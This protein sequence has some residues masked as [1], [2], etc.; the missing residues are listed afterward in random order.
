[1]FESLDL[2]PSFKNSIMANINNNSLSHA[3][4]LEGGD[5]ATRLAV[6]K[7]IA[8]AVMCK[9]ENKPCGKCDKCRKVQSDNHPDIYFLR[10]DKKSLVI[11][12]DPVRDLKR[13]ALVLPN[14]GDKSIFII[15]DAQ[16]MNHLAQ[17]AFLKIFEEPSPHVLFIL[18]CDTKAS[19]LE[20]VISR[21]TCYNLGA[22]K[23]SASASSPKKEKATT[24][25]NELLLCLVEENEVSFLKRIAVLQKDKELFRLC[26][27]EMKNILHDSLVI[28]TSSLSLVQN[29][30]DAAK[31]LSSRLTG[32]KILKLYK[33]SQEL[34]ETGMSNANQNL[35][36]TR[37]SSV[38]FSIKS[39]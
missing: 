28:T 24:L 15:V 20:T 23:A 11:K 6:A 2:A 19:L 8:A 39:K 34:Y 5:E 38:F 4:I 25:A 7:E 29:P 30:C 33:A 32:E 17:N 22:D 16:T 27:V 12:I 9:G 3:L 21:A 13:K 35:L 31:K 37:L 18:C 26:L 10:K 14:D 36:L 1:M